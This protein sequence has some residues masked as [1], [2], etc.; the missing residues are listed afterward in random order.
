MHTA[1]KFGF[2]PRIFLEVLIEMENVNIIE[3]VFNGKIL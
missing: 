3:N 1:Q 2:P